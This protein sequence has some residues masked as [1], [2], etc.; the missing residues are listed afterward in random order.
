[1]C[2]ILIRSIWNSNSGFS[3]KFLLFNALLLALC[4]GNLLS[5]NIP[6]TWCDT[7]CPTGLPITIIWGSRS[8]HL[9]IPRSQFSRMKELPLISI[10]FVSGLDVPQLP[11]NYRVCLAVGTRREQQRVNNRESRPPLG[12]TPGGA[13]LLE[14]LVSIASCAEVW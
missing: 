13:R 9:S 14:C 2:L 8:P 7:G 1:M 11:F 6:L 4:A 3:P 5:D 12:T 10:C